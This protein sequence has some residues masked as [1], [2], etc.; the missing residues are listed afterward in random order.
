MITSIL[1]VR[2]L[3]TLLYNIYVLYI[4]YDC[5]KKSFVSGSLKST[6]SCYIVI[7]YFGEQSYILNNIGRKLTNYIRLIGSNSLFNTY[8]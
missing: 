8:C 5:V 3:E 4:K 2:A 7:T 6:G 1:L